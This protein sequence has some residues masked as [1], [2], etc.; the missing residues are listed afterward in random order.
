MINTSFLENMSEY[1]K[2]G[3]TKPYEFRIDCLKKLKASIQKNEALL[4]TALEQDLGKS[5]FEALETEIGL[6][7]EEINQSLHNLKKWMR[8]KRVSTPLMHFPS[9]SK[10]YSEPFGKVLIIAPWNCPFQL[11]F[12]PL[13]GAI[14]AGNSVVLKP[15]EYATA[16]QEA[17]R[18]IVKETFHP[19]H[20][21]LIAGDKE[22]ADT[23]LDYPFDMIFF[24]GS[25]PVGKI[26]MEKASKN[27]TPV[28]LELGGKSPCIIDEGFNLELAAQRIAWGKSLNAGQTCVAPDYLFIHKEDEDQFINEYQKSIKKMYGS[29]PI[30]NSDYP[31][32]INEH[33]FERLEALLNTCHISIGGS[34]NTT[35]LKIA[36]TVVTNVSWQDAIMKDEIFGPILPVLTYTNIEDVIEQINKRPKPLACYFFST[37]KE[38]QE[39]IVQEIPFGGGCLNDTIVHL[40]TSNL[41][42]GGVGESGMGNYHG[43]FSFDAFSHQKS[44][45]SKSTLIDIPVRYPPYKKKLN[46][47]R[48]FFH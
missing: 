15:S 38:N 39:K 16:T 21:T 26:V 24:T 30:E 11:S 27:L 3:I 44:I 47:L 10:I 22:V 33:H 29:N 31:K 46:I 36:P 28:I 40:A 8:P 14:S 48:Y 37:T 32:I 23:L 41:P 42:F 13:I 6:V 12:I 45:L 20:V 17:M 18:V 9:T 7:Y 1:L 5:N 4:F 19:S 43:K 35:T 25:V 34:K 2:T